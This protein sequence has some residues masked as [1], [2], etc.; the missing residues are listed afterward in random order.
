MNWF[1]LLMWGFAILIMWSWIT[2]FTSD[3]RMC[4]QDDVYDNNCGEAE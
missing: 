2:Y 4:G 3:E 1:K